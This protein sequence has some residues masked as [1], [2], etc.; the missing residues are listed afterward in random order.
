MILY[1]YLFYFEEVSLRPVWPY[2]LLEGVL[3]GR[4]SIPSFFWLVGL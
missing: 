1:I 3:L 4:H 2:L